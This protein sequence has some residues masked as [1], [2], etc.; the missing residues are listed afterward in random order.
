MLNFFLLQVL[1][2]GE[3]LG[4]PKGLAHHENFVF[5]TEF[6]HGLVQRLNLADKT[7]T[8]VIKENPPLYQIKV[9]DVGSQSGIHLYIIHGHKFIMLISVRLN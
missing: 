4:H 8:R 6:Q 1:F 5:W 7:I 2:S 3:H 9:F